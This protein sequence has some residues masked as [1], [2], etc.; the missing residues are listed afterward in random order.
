MTNEESYSK[1]QHMHR[2]KK[3]GKKKKALRFL[4]VQ[5]ELHLWLYRHQSGSLFFPPYITFCKIWDAIFLTG[6]SITSRINPFLDNKVLKLSRQEEKK[7]SILTHITLLEDY[8]ADLCHNKHFHRC[9]II[10]TDNHH[11]QP[12]VCV[13]ATYLT[14]ISYI[15][16]MS[17]HVACHTITYYGWTCVVIWYFSHRMSALLT[18]MLVSVLPM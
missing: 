16:Y 12:C 10:T 9:R 15:D 4:K 11:V 6:G 5:F 7:P 14:L 13:W 18:Y 2:K 17:L 1:W 8:Q 3:K